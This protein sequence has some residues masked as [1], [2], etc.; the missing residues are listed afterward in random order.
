[1]LDLDAIGGGLNNSTVGNN[2]GYVWS[3]VITR[4]DMTGGCESWSIADG[5]GCRYT[6][7]VLVVLTLSKY[8]PVIVWG[9]VFS[10]LCELLSRFSTLSLFDGNKFLVTRIRAC[11]VGM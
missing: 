4:D 1:M 10:R 8:L 6:H 3:E 7:V 9:L 2:L 5:R 11:S